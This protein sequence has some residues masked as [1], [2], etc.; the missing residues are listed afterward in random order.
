MELTATTELPDKWVARLD[1]KYL[2]S[3]LFRQSF[4]QSFTEAIY[5]ENNSVGYLQRQWENYTVN[6]GFLQQQL[7]ESTAP[8]D[9]V[10]IRALPSVDLIGKD[11]QLLNGPVPLWYSFSVNSA[12]FTRDEP[13]LE[14]ETPVSREDVEPQVMTAFN[15]KG[16]SLVPSFTFHGT[17]WS[18]SL[19]STGALAQSAIFRRAGDLN[20]A[21]TLPTLERVFPAPKWLGSKIKHVIEPRVNYRYVGG[22]DNFNSLIRFDET[23]LLSDTNQLTLAIVNRFYLKQK[24]GQVRD[25][26]DWQVGQERYFDPTFGGAVVT[27]QPNSFAVTSDLMPFAFITKP[28]NYSPVDSNL[29]LNAFGRF[30]ADW[31][32]DYDPLYGRVVSNLLSGGYSFKK[33]Y[34]ITAGYRGLNPDPLI[35]G[36]ASQVTV[37]AGYGNSL[38]KGLNVATTAYYDYQKGLLEFLFSQATYNTDCCGFSLQFRRFSFGIR[39]ENQYLLSFT[40]ANVGSFGNLRRQDRIF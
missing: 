12:L 21:V 31:R 40:I 19:N 13:G 8:G 3:Y 34:F 18:D 11:Q 1:Y 29:Q 6:V 9:F 25:L 15:F 30:G 2:S 7:F 24:D 28:R 14:T 27:G 37:T 22:I 38:R 39:N 20:V 36:Y 35:E 4:S 17:S 16:F 23:E 5:S 33:G 32:L 26:L 10:Q